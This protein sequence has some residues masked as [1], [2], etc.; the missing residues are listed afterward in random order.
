MKGQNSTSK[1]SYKV[2]ETY[3]KFSVVI[4]F[5]VS[6]P[7]SQILSPGYKHIEME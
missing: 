3:L 5:L 7:F 2:N 4:A 6:S 1:T